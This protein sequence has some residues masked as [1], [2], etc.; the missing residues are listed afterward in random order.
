MMAIR[1]IL[2]S[3]LI[4][5]IVVVPFLSEGGQAE[6][7]DESYIPIN[8][9]DSF[10]Q[11]LVLLDPAD[12]ETMRSGSESDMGQYHF[13]LG[14][15]MRNSWGLWG[16]SRLAQWFGSQGI[17]HP[18]DMSGIILNSF[19]RHLNDRPI[20]LDAQIRFYQSYWESAA[21][22]GPF[23]CPNT[24]VETASTSSLVDEV[25]GRYVVSH[26]VDCG[27]NEYWMHVYDRG[28]FAATPEILERLNR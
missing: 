23:T 9:E 2:A 17:T 7:R 12:I 1:S 19:W 11:L 25:D 14:M 21:D 16:G 15:W 13:G 20:E 27:D 3:I 10:V 24:N 4:L 8:L 22:P 6:T 26:I 18:D 5:A 28:W